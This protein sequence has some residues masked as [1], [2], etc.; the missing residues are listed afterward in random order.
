MATLLVFRKHVAKNLRIMDDD[1]NSFMDECVKKVGKQ[2]MKESRALKCDFKSYN[3]HI[4]LDV[5]SECTSETLTQLL[6]SISPK[7]E[8][9][10]QSLMV[11]NIISSMVTCQP[12]PLQITIG[13]LLGDHKMFIEELY[14]YDVSCSYDEVRR[15]KRSA[16]VQSS[17]A[18]RRLAGMRD[19]TEGRLVQIIIDNFD[20]VISSQNCR[21]DCHCMAMLATQR[22]Y[23][24]QLDGL[25]TTIPRISKEDMKHPIP[26]VT[27][28]VQFEGPKKPV[29]PMTATITMAMPDDFIQATQDSLTRARDLDF[30]F[31]NDVLFRDKTPEYNGY[32]TRFC[33]EAGMSPAPKS[34]VVYLPVV[35][36]DDIVPA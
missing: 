5:A 19:V 15:F 13:V 32:N 36:V 30:M 8:N 33:R 2:I 35:V 25:D 16:A 10:P 14:K 29:M 23:L 12:T 1:E 17:K 22:K 28:V 11:G 21:L 18:N 9:S 7:F 34:A 3:K 4:D 27:P 6:S 26:C 24:N 31:L 20:A